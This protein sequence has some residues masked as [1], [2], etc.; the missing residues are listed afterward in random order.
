[1]ITYRTATLSD[2]PAL[3]KLRVLFL[4]EAGNMPPEVDRAELERSLLDYF[5]ASLADGSFAAWLALAGDRIIAT[6][7]MSFSANPPSWGSRGGKA[8]YISNMYTIP[9]YRRQ[10]IAKEI[11]RLVLSQAK[12]HGCDK[13]T[14]YA[15]DMGRSLYEKFGFHGSPGYMELALCP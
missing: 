13:I 15:T 7:G 1:M 8:V 3:A 12:T 5:E 10:G 11:F 14:L 4:I 6:S 9:E 2:A